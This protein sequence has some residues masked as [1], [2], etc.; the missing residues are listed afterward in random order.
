MKQEY[1]DIIDK[2]GKPLWWDEVGVPRYEKFHP[3]LLNDIYAKEGCL[4][5]IR[6]QFCGCK[7]KVGLSYNTFLEKSSLGE[8]INNKTIHYGDPPNYY[9]GCCQVGSSANSDSIKVIEYWEKEN[10]EW[11]RNKK[12]EI[13]VE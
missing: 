4:L 8:R 10:F 7:F 5:L 11:K 13:N 12:F 3:N 6:C 2:L 9:K 1:N